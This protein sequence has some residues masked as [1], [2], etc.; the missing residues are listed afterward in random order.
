ML[1]NIG[2]ARADANLNQAGHI[3]ISAGGM[4]LGDDR[5]V[6]HLDLEDADDLIFH[7]EELFRLQKFARK[8]RKHLFP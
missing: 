7:I 8:K 3:E 2:K 6:F 4:L 5:V 1:I